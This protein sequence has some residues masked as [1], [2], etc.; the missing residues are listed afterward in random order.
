MT[1][2]SPAIGLIDS[3]VAGLPSGYIAASSGFTAGSDGS[4]MATEA[5]DD[6]LGHGSALAAVLLRDAPVFRLLNAQVFTDRLICTAAQVAAALDWLVT[7]KVRLV[8]MSFGLREDRPILRLACERA[9]GQ[10][11]ILMAAAPARGGPVF[12]AA[13]PGVIRA[14]GDARCAPWEISFLDN[15]QADFGAHTRAGETAVIGASVGCAHVSARAL[16]F[17]AK[18]P[19]GTAMQLAAWLVE[20]SSY[21]GPER[22]L[23]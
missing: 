6:Q 5:I 20:Q 11:V 7:R 23:C 15:G 10:G 16:R 22:R 14:T 21:R 9:L 12:P 19:A 18:Y 1:H 3:G 2:A 4:A 8:N 17:F 13:Y